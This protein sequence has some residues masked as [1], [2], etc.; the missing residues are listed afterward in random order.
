MLQYGS[1]TTLGEQVKQVALRTGCSKGVAEWA[2]QLQLYVD[3][4]RRDHPGRRTAS[5]QEWGLF[6]LECLFHNVVAL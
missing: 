2:P 3:E 1:F 5:H 4:L 6:L